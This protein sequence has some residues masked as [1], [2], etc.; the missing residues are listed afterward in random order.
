MEY[1]ERLL[2]ELMALITKI[3]KLE[4]FLKNA[5]LENKEKT[6]LMSKQLDVMMAYRE[7]LA[8]RVLLEME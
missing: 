4:N 8:K 7:I 3:A 2:E 6:E 5:N 1:K